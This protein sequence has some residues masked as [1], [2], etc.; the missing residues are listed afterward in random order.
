VSARHAVNA[1]L[2][3][4]N[5]DAERCRAWEPYRMPELEP[6]KRVD[7]LRYRLGLP[8]AFDLGQAP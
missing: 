8:N 6:L 1:L 2:E 4:D 3:A 5:S 7:E